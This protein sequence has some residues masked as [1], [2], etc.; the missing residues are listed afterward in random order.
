M[1]STVGQGTVQR[2]SHFGT[3]GP[4]AKSRQCG[5]IPLMTT[6][7]QPWNSPG[8]LGGMDIIMEMGSSI[9]LDTMA[10]GFLTGSSTVAAY[11]TYLQK[12]G[13]NL[14]KLV[15]WSCQERH[16]RFSDGKV[17][18]CT[19]CILLPVFFGGRRGELL[20]YVIPGNTPFLLGKPIMEQLALALDSRKGVVRWRDKEWIRL[21]QGPDN[22]HI[23]NMAEDVEL[24]REANPEYTYV[25]VDL[26]Y[27]PSSAMPW[28]VAL[29]AEASVVWKGPTKYYRKLPEDAQFTHDLE[30]AFKR[31]RHMVRDH[32]VIWEVFIGQGRTSEEIL[33]RGGRVRT[34]SLEN[35]WNFAEEDVRVQFLLL[36]EQAQPDEVLLAPPCSPWSPIQLL[37]GRTPTGWDLLTRK[38][39]WHLENYLWFVTEVYERQR[40]SGHHAHVEH[41]AYATSWATS[42]FHMMVGYDVVFHQCE[43]GQTIPGVEGLVKMPTQVPAL[44]EDLESMA[45]RVL[46]RLVAMRGYQ[47]QIR[48]C[49]HNHSRLDV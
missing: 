21:Q 25:P 30:Q 38:R 20:A 41:P 3:S 16:F 34:F 43:Y 4:R 14:K 19:Q 1:L 44:E 12:E 42:A 6:A 37:S 26:S 36:Q 15:V 24:L 18:Q 17:A 22:D 48:G 27:D 5:G 23:L 10:S 49:F 7:L 31:A 45:N 9:I 46:E 28:N 47:E 8:G 35:G 11:L 29:R 13:V 33:R 40:C 39:E 2:C 32:R